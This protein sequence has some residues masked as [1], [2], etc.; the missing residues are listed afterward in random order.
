MAIQT[1][2]L[3]DKLPRRSKELVKLLFISNHP[4]FDVF[5]TEIPTSVIISQLFQGFLSVNDIRCLLF[6]FIRNDVGQYQCILVFSVE[7]FDFF[8]LFEYFLKIRVIDR[9]LSLSA[10]L[11]L[12]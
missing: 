7:Q 3:E 9:C 6:K 5:W 12:G 1:V 4:F 8:V 10:N 2:F 11:F